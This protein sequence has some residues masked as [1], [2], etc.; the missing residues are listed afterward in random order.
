[1]VLIPDR[2]RTPI[3]ARPS[4]HHFVARSADQLA[5]DLPHPAVLFLDRHHS[6]IP[7]A[8]RWDDQLAPDLSIGSEV[9]I[10]RHVYPRMKVCVI[11]SL[12]HTVLAPL[13]GSGGAIRV[14]S[15]PTMGGRGR[16]PRR[17]FDPIAQSI[18]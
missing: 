6:L 1:M 17:S 3:V 18:A 13:G 8:S 15:S 11:S 9:G 7:D 16:G 2:R 10:I 5:S 14:G 12:P 4:V